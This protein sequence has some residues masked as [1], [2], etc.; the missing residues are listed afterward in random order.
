MVQQQFSDTTIRNINSVPK[1][2]HN[3]IIELIML[4]NGSK[5]TKEKN[6][7]NTIYSF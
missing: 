4:H 3:N 7:G 1:N 6:V 2:E 5:G